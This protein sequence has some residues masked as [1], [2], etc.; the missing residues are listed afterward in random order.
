MPNNNDHRQNGYDKK[1][2]IDIG[3]GASLFVR[4]A[5]IARRSHM[6]WFY[7]VACLYKTP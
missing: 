4:G 2:Y 6:A 1:S 7:V 3:I 5:Q